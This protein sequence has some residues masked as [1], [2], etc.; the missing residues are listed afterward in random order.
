MRY[1]FSSYATLLFVI[2][3]IS[4]LFPGNI[5][6]QT[7][8]PVE[9]SLEKSEAPAPEIYV[10][11]VI[12]EESLAEQIE[13][14]RRKEWSI[15]PQWAPGNLGVTYRYYHN[16]TD[17]SPKLTQHGVELQ[18]HQETVENGTYDIQVEGL[19][20]DGYDGLQEPDGSRI[21]FRQKNYVIN[22][23]LLLDSDI[24]HFRSV[25]PSLVDESYR[26]RLPST[27]LQGM[28][29]RFYHGDTA[30]FFNFGEIG[31]YQGTAAK[32]YQASQGRL[33]GLGAE[34]H[35]N[36]H[37][38]IAFQLWNSDNPEDVE[39]HQSMAAAV[40]YQPDALAQNHQL[41]VL[42]DSNGKTGLWYDG[43][44]KLGRWQH[45]A[46]AQYLPPGLLWTD[47]PINNDRQGL[48]WR[49]ERNAY[50]W[51]W[52]LGSE[53]GENNLDND[54]LI[55]GY[56][57]TISFASLAWQY[58]RKTHFGGNVNVHTDWADSGTATHDIYRYTL[59][60]YA[61]HYFPIGRARIEPQ[62]KIA[63]T[64][65]EQ[66][67]RYGLRWNQEY[68]L[69]LNHNLNSE[70]QYYTSDEEEDDL[71]FKIYFDHS[72]PWGIKFNGSIQKYYIDYPQLGITQGTSISMGLGW[73]FF[74]NWLMSLNADYNTG[75]IKWEEEEDYKIE[76]I[77]LLFAISY[78]ISTGKPRQLYGFDTGDPGRGRIVG[79]VFLDE[80]RNGIFDLREKA[81]SEII[82]YLDGRNS[83]ESRSKGG[84]EFWPVA[85]GEH[86][87]T[88]ELRDVPLPWSLA[89][90]KPQRVVVPNRGEI[91][92]NF[93]LIRL[94][95]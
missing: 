93:A 31:Q 1:L 91:E 61:D 23:E 41:H 65:L 37:W 64:Y 30:L 7:P 77:N 29:N 16:D 25:V 40:E 60:A 79:R 14:D 27:I 10:D 45:R 76:G 84:F 19:T 67:Q 90:E 48:Y 15:F 56:L 6:S 52:S 81:L 69:F 46:G 4:L 26:F 87:L 66:S 73:Q 54:P 5:Y 89:D 18:W 88:L 95:E 59:R 44:I 94:N 74:T 17:R 62:V 20:S 9:D 28:G 34:H 92:F 72:Y 86:S 82:V 43:K 53:I 58:R 75:N 83:T 51:F 68:D 71:S 11:Q 49:G 78:N 2:L 85:A 21:Q 12:D 47:V 39:T 24:V 3:L 35:L 55:P 8:S 42:G 33:F 57:S 32:A 80:N 63:D 13:S 70:I 38:D 22:T 50:R 36:R